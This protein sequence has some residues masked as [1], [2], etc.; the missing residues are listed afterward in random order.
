MSKAEKP[1]G[2]ASLDVLPENRAVS[3]NTSES[4]QKANTE[5]TSTVAVENTPE[6]DTGRLDSALRARSAMA[7]H[8]NLASVVAG[9]E[10]LENIRNVLAPSTEQLKHVTLPDTR[11]NIGDLKIEI[12]YEVKRYAND[13]DQRQYAEILYALLGGERMGQLKDH[14][15]RAN[16]V[17]TP[18]LWFNQQLVV[19]TKKPYVYLLSR[20]IP[21]KIKDEKILEVN[22]DD[23]EKASAYLK[24]ALGP[25]LW[26]TLYLI[27]DTN[28]LPMYVV[29]VLISDVVLE[30][31][32]VASVPKTPQNIWDGVT[33]AKP[34]GIA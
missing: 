3:A 32:L 2:L 12:P 31:Q 23:A 15:C 7:E 33:T 28:Q 34:T 24:L 26:K 11:V 22:K 14:A 8:L 19:E 9:R 30:A 21:Q 4:N 29:F 17:H 1:T 10:P 6:F 13:M 27:A 20:N 25:D 5:W 18:A 16:Q